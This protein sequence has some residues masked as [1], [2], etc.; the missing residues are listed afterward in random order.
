MSVLWVRP[1]RVDHR[2]SNPSSFNLSEALISS[3]KANN[4]SHFITVIVVMEWVIHVKCVAQ[5]LE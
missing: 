3:K 2:G 1:K 4:N 5:H